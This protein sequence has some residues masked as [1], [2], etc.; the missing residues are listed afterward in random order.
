MLMANLHAVCPVNIIGLAVPLAILQA[1]PHEKTTKTDET[2]DAE[3][4]E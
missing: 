3:Q 1:F 4:N 2:E